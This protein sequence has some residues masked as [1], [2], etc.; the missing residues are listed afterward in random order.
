MRPD[1]KKKLKAWLCV[2]GTMCLTLM[3]SEIVFLLAIWQP[4]LKDGGGLK[5]I[6]TVI[7]TGWL[8]GCMYGWWRTVKRR[9]SWLDDITTD[10][11]LPKR[12]KGGTE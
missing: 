6:G 2:L 8:Y 7:L 5:G 10:A 4:F 9:T 11:R 3:V 12:E 1:T